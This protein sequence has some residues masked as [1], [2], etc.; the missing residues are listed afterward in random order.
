MANGTLTSGPSSNGV[1]HC[2]FFLAY[3]NGGS[4]PLWKEPVWRLGLG[5]QAKFS[6]GTD[7][8]GPG[9]LHLPGMASTHAKV[10]RDRTGIWLQT[11]PGTKTWLND[12]RVFAGP[13]SLV[14][15]DRIRF[16]LP[17]LQ[18]E[19]VTTCTADLAAAANGEGNPAT[20]AD[21]IGADEGIEELSPAE[22]EVFAWLG[23]GVNDLEE[24]AHRLSR[25]VNTVRTQI[26]RVYEKLEVHSKSE[27]LSLVLRYR[28]AMSNRI[29]SAGNGHG[30][31][32]CFR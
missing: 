2:E 8:D 6:I 4:E 7:V 13:V 30:S 21:G 15:G 31:C 17:G 25:S 14:K 27:L 20:P 12:L 19:L 11:E 29:S 24:V 9:K 5:E 10:W 1:T 22:Y 26:S 32:G 23:R 16:G 3:Y 28:M 18:N